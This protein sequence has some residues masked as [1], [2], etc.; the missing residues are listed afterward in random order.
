MEFSAVFE[1]QKLLMCLLGFGLVGFYW[2]FGFFFQQ[3]HEY[4]HQ[5]NF[6]QYLSETTLKI[7]NC[8]GK[9]LDDVQFKSF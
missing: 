7:F 8:T 3:I 9:K 1:F 4:K 6:R 5:I 2:W